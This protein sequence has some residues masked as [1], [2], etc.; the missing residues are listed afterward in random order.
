MGKIKSA[1]EIAEEKTRNIQVDQKAIKRREA[2]ER[3]KRLVSRFLEQTEGISL[4][5]EMKA[6]SKEESDAVK[7]AVVDTLLANLTLPLSDYTTSRNKL[8]RQG[9]LELTPENKTLR[10][11]LEQI[12]TFF[13]NYQTEREQIEKSLEA[14]YAPRLRQKE[15]AI[16]KQTGTR[17]ELH[18]MQD[19][20]FVTLL[21]KNL[22]MFDERY[23]EALKDAK[24]E[25]E[26]LILQAR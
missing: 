26:R 13:D 25:I 21:K 22:G 3:G 4:V 2:E 5:N 20:E 7:K 9:L 14:Q 10:Q 18:A 6:V 24:A 12:A 15:D 23:Q 1:W 19:P 16:A 11:I 8:A 17:V